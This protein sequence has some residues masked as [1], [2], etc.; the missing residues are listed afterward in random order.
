[1]QPHEPKGSG[2]KWW[3]LYFITGTIDVIQLLIGWTGVGTIISEGIE[4]FMPF[5]LTGSLMLMKI[6]LFQYPL[7]LVSILGVTGLDAVTGGIAPFWILDVWYLQHSVK[8]EDIESISV[9]NQTQI[10][11]NYPLIQDGTRRPGPP[12]L[13]ESTR[14]QNTRPLVNNGIRAPQK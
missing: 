5:L 10:S 11:N 7:R 2:W 9:S 6:S 4:I 14:N 1:M 12:P 3:T 8:K 13:P